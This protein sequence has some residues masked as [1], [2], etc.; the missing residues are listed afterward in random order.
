MDNNFYSILNIKEDSFSCNTYFDVYVNKEQNIVYKRVRN[1]NTRS[2]RNELFGNKKEIR[3]ANFIRY[4]NTFLN[5]FFNCTFNISW[6][7][8]D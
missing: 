6:L 8:R 7:T 1:G 2:I 3:H 5:H 4:K